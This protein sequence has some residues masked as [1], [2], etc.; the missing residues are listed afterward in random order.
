MQLDEINEIVNELMQNKNEEDIVLE[1]IKRFNNKEIPAKVVRLIFKE[2]SNDEKINLLNGIYDNE[3]YKENMEKLPPSILVQ[4]PE[5]LLSRYDVDYLSTLLSYI[6]IE[7]YDKSKIPNKLKKLEKVINRCKN[8]QQIQFN[9]NYSYLIKQIHSKAINKFVTNLVERS[10]VGNIESLGLPKNMTFGVE[11]EFIKIFS[12]DFKKVVRT[13]RTY[14]INYLDEFHI[15]I[16]TSVID[17]KDDSNR[18]R[19]IITYF[20]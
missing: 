19:S 2:I 20:T 8:N 10:S 6:L 14:G 1:T 12:D 16:D 15:H 13:L 9:K 11:I 5:K 4:K 17:Y 18:N 7:E 3:H